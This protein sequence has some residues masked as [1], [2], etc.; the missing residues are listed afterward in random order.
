MFLGILVRPVG[1]AAAFLLANV[2]FAG[3]EVHQN[4]VLLL[5]AC[6]IACSVGRAGRRV[7]FDELLDPRLPTW[8]TWAPG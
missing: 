4:Y 5:G 2:Y 3:P 1:W 6:A 8:L 7:G